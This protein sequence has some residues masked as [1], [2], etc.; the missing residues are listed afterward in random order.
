LAELRRSG[1]KIRS[2]ALITT[3]W[4]RL[5]LGDLFIHGIGGGNYDHVT[6]TIIER[7]FGCAPPQLMVLSATLLLPIKRQAKL[8]EEPEALTAKLRELTYHPEQFLD[9]S[10]TVNGLIAE[11][12]NWIK[13]PQ[14]R[15]NAKQRCRVIRD[16]NERLQPL[17]VERRSQIERRHELAVAE[18]RKEKILNWREYAFCLYPEE[19]IR[20]FFD[21]LLMDIS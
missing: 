17:L 2:R 8:V 16:I 7:F 6:D 15:E 19:T 10:N 11:K 1:V 20:D 14:T 5:M 3:L 4:A 9:D 12:L 18:A 21:G 13:T